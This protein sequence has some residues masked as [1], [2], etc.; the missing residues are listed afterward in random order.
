MDALRDLFLFLKN[1][2][3]WWLIPLILALLVMGLLMVF[4]EG[5]AV[6]TFIYPL[7]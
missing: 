4:A 6:A 5:S 1:Q 2:K 7:F 3:K